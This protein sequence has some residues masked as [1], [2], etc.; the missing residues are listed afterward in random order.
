MITIVIPAPPVL[1]VAPKGMLMEYRSSSRPSF[2]QSNMLIGMFAAELL[3]KNAVIP[4]SFRQMKRRGYG[5]RLRII[6]TI[7]GYKIN[8]AASIHPTI[9]KINWPY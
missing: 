5:L 3:V 6:A 7:R 8:V 2:L 1:I 4:L 9:N